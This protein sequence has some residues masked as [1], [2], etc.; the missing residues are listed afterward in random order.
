[1][2][3]ITIDKKALAD[4]IKVKEDFDAIIESLELMNNKEFM[5]SYKKSKEQVKKRQ[6]V[7]WNEL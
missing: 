4:L 3:T 5:N 7:E 1:M 2:E 6:F